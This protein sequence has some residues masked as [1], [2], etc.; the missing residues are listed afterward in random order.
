[1]GYGEAQRQTRAPVLSSLHS[2]EWL[3]YTII[4]PRR[5]PTLPRIAIGAWGREDG[6]VCGAERIVALAV[7]RLAWNDSGI[8]DS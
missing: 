3:C 1:M 6:G 8:P 5:A 2:Q 7:R 4:S